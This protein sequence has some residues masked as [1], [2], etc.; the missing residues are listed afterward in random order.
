MISYAPFIEL[1]TEIAMQYPNVPVSEIFYTLLTWDAYNPSPAYAFP[2]LNVDNKDR[3]SVM[4]LPYN[5]NPRQTYLDMRDVIDK[6]IAQAKVKRTADLKNLYSSPQRLEIFTKLINEFH[7]PISNA[8][9]LVN[10]LTAQDIQALNSISS[11]QMKVLEDVVA[12]LMFSSIPTNCHTYTGA[13]NLMHTSKEALAEVLRVIHGEPAELRAVRTSD[14]NCTATTLSDYDH[15]A[16]IRESG[17]TELHVKLLAPS[18]TDALSAKNADWQ[19]DL[20]F[21]PN[22]EE[23]APSNRRLLT[24]AN[25]AVANLQTNAAATRFATPF[26]WA[27]DF[28]Q[29]VI[30]AVEPSQLQNI[31]ASAA[32]YC[33]A[34]L[35]LQSLA[36]S[37]FG[38]FAATANTATYVLEEPVSAALGLK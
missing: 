16:K 12:H 1:V 11:D 20:S 22:L 35:D 6:L 23:L 38:F 8:L 36:R 19:M 33:A 7:L 37:S 30:N 17:L 34:N 9:E 15:V 4:V 2:L 31:L 26:G 14:R 10:D 24:V 25:G 32:I 5:I 3:V 27:L 13:V 21:A 29:S 18:V 28:L